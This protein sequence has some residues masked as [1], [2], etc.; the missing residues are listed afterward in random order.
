MP[1]S[2]PQ[3]KP[4]GSY[5][6]PHDAPLRRRDTGSCTG[7]EPV[8]VV[9]DATASEREA[10]DSL[11]ALF[12]G[13]RVS[14]TRA[15]L[16]SLES[17]GLG[18][19]LYI[20][21][22]RGGDV[23][24]CLP[25]MQTRVGLLKLFG[26]PLPGWQ[27]VSMGPVF[28]AS[29]ISAAELMREVVPFLEGRYGIHHIELMSSSLGREAMEAAGFRGSPAPSFVVP[30]YPGDPARVMRGMKDS[31][32]RNVKRAIRLGLTVREENDADFVREHFDQIREV[33]T[34]RGFAV[35]FGARRVEAYVDYMRAAG[36]LVALSVY[37]PDGRTCIATATFTIA[38][39]EMVLWMWTHRTEHRWFRPT[40]LM[41]WTAMQRAMEAGCTSLDFMGRGDFK[42]QLGAAP[43][44]SKIRWV[45]S[46]Y[47]WLGAARNAAERAYRVQQ[48]IRGRII[49][50]LHRGATADSHDVPERVALESRSE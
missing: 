27:T 36:R 30:L 17:I 25:G 13:W 47:A 33:F 12:P 37:L 1:V 3:M 21:F 20:V 34:R 4:A 22:E 16:D 42:A 35:P 43:D 5:G 8:V 48:S 28:D 40:E 38:G 44:E 7:A 50:T 32:R 2:S 15:W 31:A 23:V 49:R 6:S 14:H 39:D 24:G 41:T 19:A 45:R 11:I 9:R 46:R 26:S 18:R 10:W 29:R